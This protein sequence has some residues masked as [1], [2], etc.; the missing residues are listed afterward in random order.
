M[1][2]GKRLM[3]IKISNYCTNKRNT[4]CCYVTVYPDAE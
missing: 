4:L 2:K 1:S 3:D